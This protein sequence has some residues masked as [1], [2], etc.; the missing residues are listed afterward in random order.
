MMLILSL[1]LLAM[2][3]VTADGP[4]RAYR[5]SLFVRIVRA[6]FRLMVIG[7]QIDSIVTCIEG[8]IESSPS[9]GFFFG[10]QSAFSPENIEYS[11]C[12]YR[13]RYSLNSFTVLTH[14]RSLS[15]TQPYNTARK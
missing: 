15:T 6:F 2:P 12:C 8:I 5:P 9:S 3:G 14:I 7:S 10:C 11:A 1:A 4:V 13:T